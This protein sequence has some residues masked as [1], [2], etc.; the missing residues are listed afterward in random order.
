MVRLNI[1]VCVL[2]SFIPVR[3]K[4]RARH[5]VDPGTTVNDLAPRET[6]D[7][8]WAA[9]VNGKTVRPDAWNS[10]LLGN[11]SQVIYTEFPADPITAL[12]TWFF[13]AEVLGFILATYAVNWGIAQIIGTPEIEPFQSPG[14]RTYSFANLQQ[15]ASTGLPIQIVYGTHPVA[16]NVVELDLRGFNPGEGD[17]TY[18]STLDMTIA[19][20]EGEIAEVSEISISGNSI[21]AY[22][23]LAS[24]SYRLGS[25]T[26]TALG[27]GGASTTVSLNLPITD[28]ARVSANIYWLQGDW[29]T[30]SGVGNIRQAVNGQ[31]PATVTGNNSATG[32]AKLYER[33]GNNPNNDYIWIY[34]VSVGSNL[35]TGGW[36]TSAANVSFPGSGYSGTFNL[37]LTPFS[38]EGVVGNG[39]PAID[40]VADV[41]VIEGASTSYS[42]GSAVD[43]LRININF[44]DGLYAVGTGGIT[45]R[46]ATMEMRFSNADTPGTWTVGGGGTDGWFTRLIT[47]NQVGN[48]IWSTDIDFSDTTTWVPPIGS[49]PS[50]PQSYN[51]E[52]RDAAFQGGDG[53]YKMNL[54]SVVEIVDQ[55][56]TYPNIALIRATITADEAINGSSLPNIV[57]TVVGRKIQRWDGADAATPVFEPDTPSYNNPAW[58]VYDLITN[59]RYGLGNW[60]DSS[61][62]DLDSFKTWADWCN[63][64]VPDGEGGT[65]KRAIWNGVIDKESSSWDACLMVC[66][67]ARATLYTVGELIRVKFERERP[68]TQMFS[69]ANILEGSFSQSYVSRLSRPTRLDVRYLRADSNYQ[70]DTAGV[71]D[72]DA[73]EAQLPQRTSV[74]Q[75]AGITRESQALREARFRLNLEKLSTVVSWKSSID[76]VACEPGDLCIL[77]HDVPKWGTSGRVVS[78]SSTTVTLDDDVVFGNMGAGNSYQI[79]VRHNLDDSREI[80]DISSTHADTT[81]ASGS[82]ITILSAW[83]T[84]PASLDIYAIGHA[85]NIAKEIV[86]TSI[87]TSGD[88]TRSIEGVVYDP[89]IHDDGVIVNPLSIPFLPDPGQPPAVVTDLAV[90]EVAGDASASAT[91]VFAALAWQYPSGTPLGGARI[92]QREV[93]SSDIYTLTDTVSWPRTQVIIQYASPAVGTPP[94]SHEIAVVAF[95]TDGAQLLPTAAPTI[96]FTPSGVTGLPPAVTGVSLSQDMDTLRIAWSGITTTPISRYEVRRGLQWAGSTLLG[97]TTDSEFR[98]TDWTPT[99]TSG[100]TENYF[101]RAVGSTNLHGDVGIATEANTF[102]SWH[103]GTA[104]DNDFRDGGSWTG[105]ALSNMAINADGDLEIVSYGTQAKVQT[106]AYDMSSAGTYR[107]GIVAHARIERDTW[108]SAGYAWKSQDGGALTWDGYAE[109]SQLSSN[110]EIQYRTRAS[111]TGAWSDWRPMATQTAVVAFKGIQL[112]VQITPD[113]SE[114]KPLIEQLY[115]RLET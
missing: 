110:F 12:I 6:S 42:T 51:I 101:V 25:N 70:V 56:Y 19:L 73:I 24:W 23:D 46:T 1:E 92:Y 98:T 114:D 106:S 59:T 27:S 105:C 78:A 54:D 67:S 65:E 43:T 80:M 38:Q 79:I 36:T 104:R 41:A 115:V 103:S 4:S 109:R 40:Q 18:G 5:I 50:T 49:D 97:T 89:S 72:P 86:I 64:L 71:D 87:R 10:T 75:L 34:D 8:N 60:V 55:V 88:L 99:T 76:S 16:G 63:E 58:I 44:P 3:Y 48:F 111:D 7:G 69:M 83:S 17:S 82:P 100:I 53:G 95:S 90:L 47:S 39:P 94:I 108:D 85:M 29:S 33:S 57:A 37:D 102:P 68:V 74:V 15:T 30:G 9:I 84:I 91:R 26:Q 52:I 28:A 62:I 35:I 20:C 22:S 96:T 31:V 14:N 32:T 11:K 13:S 93:N 61:N 45:N 21:T 77:S 2:E 113:D 66:S 107:F 112:I 81:V